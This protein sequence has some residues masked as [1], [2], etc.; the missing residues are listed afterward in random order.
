MAQQLSTRGL[1]ASA[2]KPSRKT[3][4]RP[5]AIVRDAAWLERQLKRV[6]A[7]ALDELKNPTAIPS[8]II[9]EALM[10]ARNI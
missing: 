9:M 4:A 5:K 6:T 1:P 2:S 3:Q 8:R 7:K 10:E